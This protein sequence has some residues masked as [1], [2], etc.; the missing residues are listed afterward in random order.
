MSRRRVV[1]GVVFAAGVVASI[2]V[3]G[4]FT[5]TR[6]DP[7]DRTASTELVWHVSAKKAAG[8]VPIVAESLWFACQGT[9]HRTPLP[10]GITPVE[11]RPNTFRAVLHPALGKHARQRLEGCIEDGTL[12]RIIGRVEWM[13]KIAPT[14]GTAAPTSGEGRRAPG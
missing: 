10:P 4:D 11:G 6:P 9:V 7:V 14:S 12:D 3:L 5:Q 2:D 8:P 13:R 1:A